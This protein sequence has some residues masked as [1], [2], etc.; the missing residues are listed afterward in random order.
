MSDFSY[1]ADVLSVSSYDAEYLYP[2][3]DQLS[4]SSYDPEDYVFEEETPAPAPR[5]SPA[6][7]P[8]RRLCFPVQR[9][10]QE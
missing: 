6:A 2:D 8:R 10:R 9:K 5:L 4:G 1:D 7:C 3:A